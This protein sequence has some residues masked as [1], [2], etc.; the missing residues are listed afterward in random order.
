[1]TEATTVILESHAELLAD[2]LGRILPIP[3]RG[4]MAFLRCLAPQ[5]VRALADTPGF[6]VSGWDVR[7]VTDATDPVARTITAD[8]AVEIRENKGDATLLLVDIHAAGAGMDGI[9]N[10]TREITEDEV[11]KKAIQRARLRLSKQDREVAE[12]AVKRATRVG[13]RSAVSLW[14]QFDYYARAVCS[15][16][17]IG[18]LVGRLGL[19]PIRRSPEGYRKEDLDVSARLVER[20]LLGGRSEGTLPGRIRSLMLVGASEEQLRSLEQFLRCAAV[21]P[22]EEALVELE[23]KPVLWLGE[24]QPAIGGQELRRLELRSWRTRNGGVARWSGLTDDDGPVPVFRMDPHV[25][26]PAQY[27]KLEIRWDTEPEEVP[28]GH[29]E[30]QVVV[31]AGEEEL[32]SQV[33]THSRRRPQVAR[34]TNEDF[35]DLA[36]D[37]K[38]EARVRVTAIGLDHVAA[39]ES[40]EEFLLCFGDVAKPPNVGSGRPVRALLEA[41]LRWRNPRRSWK[42]AATQAYAQRIERGLSPFAPSAV[43][44]A[45]GYSVPP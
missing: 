38:F 21:L 26:T 33:I 44:A 37:A 31:L 16:S 30:Y 5:V 28:A 19:W 1:M 41:P 6:Q 34:F 12:K 13:E 8:Q 27:S 7:A 35:E 24:L 23:D 18:G 3:E 25:E 32:A 11:L 15:S 2:A 42:P 36:E 40:D 29:V 20:L 45:S 39:D 14:R 4:S 10:A 9:Y 43:V 22:V 17:G